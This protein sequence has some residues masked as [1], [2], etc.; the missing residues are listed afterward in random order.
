M[1]VMKNPFKE[2]RQIESDLIRYSEALQ[3]SQEVSYEQPNNDVE[4]SEITFDIN[5][6]INLLN[7][8][9][10][11]IEILKKHISVLY[12]QVHELQN[13][14]K[15]KRIEL[16]K[17]QSRKNAIEL[18]RLVG[19]PEEIELISPK[20]KISGL[21]SEYDVEDQVD[22]LEILKSIR[23]NDDYD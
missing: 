8:T 7:T 4:N 9:V 15:Q 21:I 1:V 6:V 2:D 3:H 11:E 20:T 23:E 22:S 17:A 10:E 12:E 18:R 13:N 5:A 14:D 19:L 16:L